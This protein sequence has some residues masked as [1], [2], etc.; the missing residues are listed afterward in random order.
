MSRGKY[1]VIA[2]VR[3]Y[4]TRRQESVETL[5]QAMQYAPGVAPYILDLLFK[6]MDAPGANEVED[7]IKQF[8]A[9]QTQEQNNGNNQGKS[10]TGGP[11]GPVPPAG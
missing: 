2:D 7:R 8:L 9:S 3:Q 1:D 11:G 5:L 6:F 4:A 10:G